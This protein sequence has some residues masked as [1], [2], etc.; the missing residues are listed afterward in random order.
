MRRC[1]SS[2]VR[3]TPPISGF[4]GS[5]KFE[6]IVKNLA[7]ILCRWTLCKTANLAIPTKCPDYGFCGVHSDHERAGPRTVAAPANKIEVRPRN[8]SQCHRSAGDVGF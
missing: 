5:L 6:S 8:W 1:M 4:D 2:I 7:C 3:Y